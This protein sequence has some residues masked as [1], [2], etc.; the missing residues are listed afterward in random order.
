MSRSAKKDDSGEKSVAG[1]SWM[2]DSRRGLGAMG[3]PH[4]IDRG[5]L[6]RDGLKVIFNGLA[7]IL[8]DLSLSVIPLALTTALLRLMEPKQRGCSAYSQRR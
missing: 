8:A 2:R 7:M 6:R 4:H 3:D 5:R 1:L